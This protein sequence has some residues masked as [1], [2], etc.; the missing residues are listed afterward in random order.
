MDQRISIDNP[1][2]LDL[3]GLMRVAWKRKWVVICVTVVAAIVAVVLALLAKPIYRAEVV[4]TEVRES[5]SAGG[6]AGQLGGLASAAGITL[7]SGA[8]GSHSAQAV[9]KSRHLVEEFVKRNNLIPELFKGSKKQPTLWLAVKRFQEGILRISEDIRGGRTTLSVDWTDPKTAAQWANGLVALANELI[10]TR[11]LDE[12]TRNVAY[13]RE[14]INK[15]TVVELQKVMYDLIESETK[16]LMLANE[17]AEYAFTVVD[18]AVAPELR[19]SPQRTL[20]VIAGT[21]IG[22]CIGIVFAFILDI[23]V[24]RRSRSKSAQ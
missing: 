22:G 12:A 4:I 18:P 23:V 5:T 9:L 7:G 20:M 1:I 8:A 2:A 16:T 21:V 17:R 24:S 6:L 11:A 10:R 13:L 15:T 14:Q 3:P 19:I